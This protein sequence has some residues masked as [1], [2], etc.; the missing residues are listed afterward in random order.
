M[1]REEEEDKEK[2]EME[3]R[4]RGTWEEKKSKESQKGKM[5]YGRGKHIEEEII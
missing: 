4:K 5:I 2:I 3:A 1:R